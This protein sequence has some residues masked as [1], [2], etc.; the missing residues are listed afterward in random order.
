MNNLG[1]CSG[2]KAPAA[3]IKNYGCYYDAVILHAY[4]ILCN[5]N[6]TNNDPMIILIDTKI[7]LH[8]YKTNICPTTMQHVVHSRLS[9]LLDMTRLE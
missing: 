3:T 1:G 4:Q 5:S 2:W 8:N 7:S 9:A 6:A